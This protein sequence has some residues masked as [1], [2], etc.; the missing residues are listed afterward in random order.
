MPFDLAAELGDLG[1]DAGYRGGDVGQQIGE[2][3][4]PST[5]RG[6]AEP[7]QKFFDDVARAPRDEV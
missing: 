6:S 7:D 5:C 4:P 2:L 3:D 1:P